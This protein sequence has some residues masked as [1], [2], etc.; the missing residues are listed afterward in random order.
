MIVY[1]Q[2]Y[3]F[4]ILCSYGIGTTVFHKLIHPSTGKNFTK[5]LI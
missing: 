4:M 3:F 1:Q 5:K 2:K